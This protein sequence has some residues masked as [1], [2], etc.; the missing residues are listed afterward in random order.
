MDS[1]IRN[2]ED[3]K[4]AKKFIRESTLKE[5]KDTFCIMVH[6]TKTKKELASLCELFGNNLMFRLNLEARQ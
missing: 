6:R 3:W 5:L 4:R 2:K 1:V